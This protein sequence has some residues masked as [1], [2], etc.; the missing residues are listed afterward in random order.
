[1]VSLRKGVCG[2]DTLLLPG[3]LFLSTHIIVAIFFLS[4]LVSRGRRLCADISAQIRYGICNSISCVIDYWCHSSPWWMHLPV[5]IFGAV[6]RPLLHHN[7][8]FTYRHR[9]YWTTRLTRDFLYTKSFSEPSSPKPQQVHFI[10]D[11]Q[12]LSISILFLPKHSMFCM[13]ETLHF[14]TFFHLE[15][16]L[17]VWYFIVRKGDTNVQVNETQSAT[18]IPEATRGSWSSKLNRKC[19]VR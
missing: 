16:S 9:L 7:R 11:R 1:M 4:P 8:F 6:G 13:I 17:P 12:R 15:K 19:E 5:M 3:Y 2:P 18:G 14:Y 10:I